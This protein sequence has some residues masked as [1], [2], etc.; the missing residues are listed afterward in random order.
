MATCDGV[1]AMDIVIGRISR[2]DRWMDEY[3]RSSRGP[4]GSRVDA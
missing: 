1:R 4:R 2:Q 3:G